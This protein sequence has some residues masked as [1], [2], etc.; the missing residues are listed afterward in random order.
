M[1]KAFSVTERRVAHPLHGPSQE[2]PPSPGAAWFAL[3]LRSRF[4]FAVRDA[5][6]AQGI[7]QFL[8]TRA[9]T[10]RWTDRQVVTTKPLFSGYIFGRFDPVAAHDAVL[11]TRGVVQILGI[12]APEAVPD[13]VIANLQRIAAQPSPVSLCPYVAGETVTVARGPFAGV[14][15]VISRVKG[16]SSLSIPVAILGRAVSVA[17][18]AADIDPAKKEKPC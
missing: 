12:G 16:A 2:A 18:D 15:G 6:A 3:R 11:R 8:P 13:A 9:E 5:L 7:D 1:Q 4:E 14:T 10:A 17:I